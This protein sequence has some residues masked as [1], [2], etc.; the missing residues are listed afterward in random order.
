LRVHN[1][2]VTLECDD[3]FKWIVF[4][5]GF[6]DDYL[7]STVCTEIR[8]VSKTENVI[9]DI[10]NK[11]KVENTINNIISSMPYKPTN[12]EINMVRAF[13]QLD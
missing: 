3:Y 5:K 9:L 11:E 12:A 6:D 1:E 2:I 8:K 10:P 13:S 4:F 7:K